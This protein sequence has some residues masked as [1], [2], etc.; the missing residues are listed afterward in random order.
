[1]SPPSG[2]P[3]RLG[4]SRPFSRS[5]LTFRWFRQ[6]AARNGAVRYRAVQAAVILTV[7]AAVAG[8]TAIAPLAASARVLPPPAVAQPP[9][10]VKPPTKPTPW[11]AATARP[12]VHQQPVPSLPALRQQAIA[13]AG[14]VE[15]TASFRVSPAVLSYLTAALG[16]PLQHT[17]LFTGV[18][19][20][21]QLLISL[22]APQ[23]RASLPPGTSMP[24]FSRSVLLLNPATG[25]ATLTSSA[26]GGTGALRVAIGDA[27]STA[28][29]T[30]VPCR[31]ACRYSASRSPWQ[32]RLTRRERSA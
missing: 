29:A 1:M 4:S 24:A 10:Q 13:Q 11:S 27:A 16:L 31:C 6:H 23:P 15:K 5:L 30:S 8:A 28:P 32:A 3:G 26:P 9:K 17:T 12:H 7:T 25:A 22:P 2:A 18:K 21:Q 14:Q 20:G 19:D